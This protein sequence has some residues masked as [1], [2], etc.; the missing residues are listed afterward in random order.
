[1]PSVGAAHSTAATSD[2]SEDEIPRTKTWANLARRQPRLSM[3]L[4]LVEQLPHASHRSGRMGT[5]RA[6][7]GASSEIARF[8]HKPTLPFRGSRSLTL[9]RW[10][11]VVDP[12]AVVVSCAL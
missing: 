9:K 1:M 11:C 3:I 7:I 4:S 12:E 8:S 5:D 10:L 6:G 2:H